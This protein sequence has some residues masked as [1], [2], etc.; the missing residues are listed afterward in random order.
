MLGSSFDKNRAINRRDD[1]YVWFHSFKKT[2]GH[3]Q[4]TKR[5]GRVVW[6]AECCDWDPVALVIPF[7]RVEFDERSC[8]LTVVDGPDATAPLEV[9]DLDDIGGL[10]GRLVVQAG[11]TKQLILV[12]NQEDGRER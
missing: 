1:S 9:V 4:K 12:E 10:V 11:R 2:R 8:I 5:Y 7:K 3:T 6:F